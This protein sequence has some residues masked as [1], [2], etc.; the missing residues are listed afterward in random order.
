MGSTAF[1]HRSRALA[2]ALVCAL[3]AAG[4]AWAQAGA[5]QPAAPSATAAPAAL[6]VAIVFGGERRGRLA[7]LPADGGALAREVTLRRA[8]TATA[9]ARGA[10]A[11]IGLDIGDTL[12]PDPASRR[13]RG[14]T[15]LRALARSG[16]NVLVPGPADLFLGVEPLSR[17]TRQ[18]VH[19]RL[20][21]AS[22]LDATT[23]KH[24]FRPYVI[25]RVGRLR[26]AIIGVM[27][28]GA[29]TE[30]PASATRR[31]RVLAPERAVR[32]AL[33]EI[34]EKRLAEVIVCA[35][36]LRA[37][38]ARRLV[39][40]L[41]RLDAAICGGA[42][43]PPAVHATSWEFGPESRPQR[44]TPVIVQAPPAAGGLG[45]LRLRWVETD[46]GSGAPDRARPRWALKSA[47]V[48]Y[49]RLDAQI[50]PDAQTA[51][52][53]AL[54]L[55]AQ[56]ETLRTPLVRD[57]S[58]VFGGPLDTDRFA[59]V[60]ASI[61]REKTHTDVAIVHRRLLDERAIEEALRRD[62][63]YAG[64][65]ERIVRY[66]DRVVTG[67]LRGAD[68]ARLFRRHGGRALIFVGVTKGPRGTT[69]LNGPPIVDNR[70]YTVV[71][72]DFLAGPG[73]PYGELKRLRGRASRF[74]VVRDLCLVP[75][76]DEIAEPVAIRKVLDW[77]LNAE[78]IPALRRDAHEAPEATGFAHYARLATK[79]KPEW[80]LALDNVRLTF[81]AVGARHDERFE[82]VRDV[83]ANA[84]RQLAFSGAG[85]IRLVR[86]SPWITATWGLDGRYTRLKVNGEK[87]RASE[88]DL[89]FRTDLTPV[90]LTF[91]PPL[92]P[93]ELAPSGS[94]EYD[95]EF[96]KPDVDNAHRQQEAFLTLGLQTP[97]RQGGVELLRVGTFASYNFTSPQQRRW[98]G[99]FEFEARYRRP[100]VGDLTLFTG[101]RARWFPYDQDPVDGDLSWFLEPQ[102]ILTL[103]VVYDIRF[104]LDVSGFLFKEHAS[105]R[106]GSQYAIAFGLSF[107]QLWRLGHDRFLPPLD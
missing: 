99:G 7:D 50:P 77:V 57:L 20:V 33:A 51:R 72:S 100:L 103:P 29:Q 82:A 79:R 65:L 104:V 31:V 63:L 30:L 90:F 32:E 76:S 58:A 81:T 19:P 96:E 89:R 46:G 44:A 94:A 71:T 84:Q 56:R 8:L 53:V 43:Q 23:A 18:G 74:E 62:A 37:E 4:A 2:I 68:L 98:K 10:G 35:G 26:L 36:N 45:L 107:S 87:S 34:T 70:W 22:L 54:R 14:R 25:E 47:S 16:C 102:C 75:S 5:P 88:D 55:A 91:S 9:R 105:A 78:V 92:L 39:R 48:V 83:R 13:D 52:E 97:Y 3:G 27:R 41:P 38:T 69:T 85:R 42:D 101:V 106:I 73:S 49:R 1:E 66:D 86:E 40:A 12:L 67:R 15:I 80:V 64:D 28:A 61:L 93:L 6:E 21:S 24:L 17:A 60:L 95:T 11:V 59:L